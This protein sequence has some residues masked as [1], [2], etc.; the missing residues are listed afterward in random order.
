[1]SGID[2]TAALPASVVARCADTDSAHGATASGAN[3]LAAANPARALDELAA[4]MRRDRR[5][6]MAQQVR[7]AREARALGVAS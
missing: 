7:R 1:V 3:Y 5:S 4:S 2:Y 6:W